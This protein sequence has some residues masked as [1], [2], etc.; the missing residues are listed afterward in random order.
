MECGMSRS[1]K[2]KEKYVYISMKEIWCN[3]DGTPKNKELWRYVMSFE[4][5]SSDIPLN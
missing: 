4:S 3:L 2:P 5:R 1:V